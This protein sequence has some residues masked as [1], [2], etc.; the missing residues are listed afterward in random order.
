MAFDSIER[1]K[2]EQ[3]SIANGL[4]KEKDIMM[5]YKSTKALVSLSDGDTEFFEIVA[6]I[7]REDTLVPYTFI[8][9]LENLLHQSMD[10]IKE[11]CFTLI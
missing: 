6:E 11:N 3:I 5:L 10:L 9:C 4:H 2:M 8:I 1:G 7:R